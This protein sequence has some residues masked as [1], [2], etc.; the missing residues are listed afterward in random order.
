ARDSQHHPDA[1]RGTGARA[2]S[3]HSVETECNDH[4]R[5]QSCA[6]HVTDRAERKSNTEI[7]WVETVQILKDKCRRRYPHKQA[8]VARGRDAEISKIRQVARNETIGTK[9]R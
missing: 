6:G 2:Y 1:T 3:K 4:A 9:D 8:G 7:K 5:C